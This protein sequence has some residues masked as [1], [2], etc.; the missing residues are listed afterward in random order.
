VLAVSL[1]I[2]SAAQTGPLL[3][4]DRLLVMGLPTPLA[5]IDVLLGR[6]VADQLLFILDG[7]RQEFTI[8]D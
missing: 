2:P 8:A 7:P 1:S 5:G 3:V 6:D 4:L